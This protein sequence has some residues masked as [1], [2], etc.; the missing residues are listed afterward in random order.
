MW[1]T[2]RV[3]VG[4]RAG[5]GYITG[6]GH[7]AGVGHIEGVADIVGV[8]PDN[9]LFSISRT[10]FQQVFGSLHQFVSSSHLLVL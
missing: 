6:V 5:V 8:G 9:F 1:A 4:H 10:L 3:Y 7:I 2:E